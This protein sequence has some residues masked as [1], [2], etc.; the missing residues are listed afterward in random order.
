MKHSSILMRPTPCCEKTAKQESQTSLLCTKSHTVLALIQINHVEPFHSWECDELCR[1]VFV[2]ISAG[3]NTWWKRL[4]GRH[5]A[6]Q[7]GRPCREEQ[8]T[9]EEVSDMSIAFIIHFWRETWLKT[10]IEMTPDKT[11]ALLQWLRLCFIIFTQNHR[12]PAIMSAFVQSSLHRFNFAHHEMWMWGVK[13]P[14]YSVK[15]F[16]WVREHPNVV[17]Q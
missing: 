16:F 12:W 2:L 14:I 10:H 8:K 3:R 6:R 13:A 5:D 1:F 11:D 7:T 15:F 9:A 17:H 4:T